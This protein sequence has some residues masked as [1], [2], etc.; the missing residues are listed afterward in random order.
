MTAWRFL[1]WETDDQIDFPTPAD[2]GPAVLLTREGRM[3]SGVLSVTVQGEALPLITFL[4]DDGTVF[5]FF[6]AIAWR[7][8]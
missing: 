3:L 6:D 2:G 8:A 4:P 5:D 1:N 7:R